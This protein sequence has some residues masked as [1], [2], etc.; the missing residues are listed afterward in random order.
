MSDVQSY[1]RLH[2][3]AI[4]FDHEKEDLERFVSAVTDMMSEKW[5]P[6]GAVSVAMMPDDNGYIMIQTFVKQGVARSSNGPVH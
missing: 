3:G 2:K 4:R 5:Y 6:L 1:F